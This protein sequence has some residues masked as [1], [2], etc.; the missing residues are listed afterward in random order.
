MVEGVGEVLVE[1]VQHNMGLLLLP[2][3]AFTFI[4]KN[5]L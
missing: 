4:S 1:A 5:I 2:S 3:P